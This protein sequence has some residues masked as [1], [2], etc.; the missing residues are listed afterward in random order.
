MI[1]F[2]VYRAPKRPRPTRI[3]YPAVFLFDDNWDDFGYKTLF[4]ASIVI[5]PQ[6]EEI[7]LGEVKILELSDANRIYQP[8]IDDKFTSL[9]SSFCSLGQ[10]VRYYRHLRDD[11]PQKI[12]RQ[13]LRSLRD[14]ISRPKQRPRFEAADGFETSLLRNGSARDALRRGAFTLDF[15]PM[16]RPHR[17][18]ALLCLSPMRLLPMNWT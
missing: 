18:S 15:Q 16:K 7:E 5:E 11:L 10:S 1:H 2:Y 9:G 14:I 6:A 13:Y 3:N 4:R 8:R 17:D 12:R